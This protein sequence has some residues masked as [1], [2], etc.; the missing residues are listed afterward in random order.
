MDFVTW[1]F[2]KVKNCLESCCRRPCYICGG[3]GMNGVT[4]DAQD[5]REMVV[6]RNGS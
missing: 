1:V 3:N 5:P 2:R 6:L 4:L